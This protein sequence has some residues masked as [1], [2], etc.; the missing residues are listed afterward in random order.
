MC[1]SF[2][3]CSGKFSSVGRG[4]KLHSDSR[5]ITECKKERVECENMKVVIKYQKNMINYLNVC[6]DD[7]QDVLHQ[8]Q[9]CTEC[10]QPYL[11]SIAEKYGQV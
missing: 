6:G 5:R 2:E 7:K 8:I 11:N 10:L 4:Q 9:A 1:K 3:P